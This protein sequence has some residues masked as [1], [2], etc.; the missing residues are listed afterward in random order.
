V[1]TNE[2]PLVIWGSGTAVSKAH[3]RQD[4]VLHAAAPWSRSVMALLKHLEA[5]GFE[6]APRPVRRYS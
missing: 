6:G 4:V 2:T 3:L 5:V 1:S